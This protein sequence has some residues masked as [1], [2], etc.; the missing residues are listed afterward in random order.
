M[1]KERKIF[2][3]SQGNQS[4]SLSPDLDYN[5]QQNCH[6]T[7]MYFRI[8][9]LVGLALAAASL[10]AGQDLSYVESINSLATGRLVT[11]DTSS[12][13]VWLN[14]AGFR[15]DKLPYIQ[16]DVGINSFDSFHQLTTI[17]GLAKNSRQL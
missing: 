8:F 2:L 17:A 12:G 5:L 1:K 14:V 10:C 15:P 13:T 6:Y 7:A 11:S 4:L 16:E 9:E 3:Q